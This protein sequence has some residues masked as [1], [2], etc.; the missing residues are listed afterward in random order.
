MKYVASKTAATIVSRMS[1]TNGS[2]RSRERSSA[3]SS[4]TRL[5]TSVVSS[6][7]PR[8]RLYRKFIA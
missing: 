2:K 3:S 1:V 4:R 5:S 7:K 6:E 8:I